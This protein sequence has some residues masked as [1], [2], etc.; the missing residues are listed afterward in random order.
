MAETPSRAEAILGAIEAAVM[1]MRVSLP[2]RIESYDASKQRA[3]I[4]IQLQHMVPDGEG[5]F[6]PTD[7]PILPNVPIMFPQ[8]NGFFV[9]FPLAKGDPV[10][11][12]FCDLPIGTWLQKGSKCEPGTVRFHGLGGAVAYPGL[13][14]S[15]SPL[16]DASG[17]NMVMGKD[18]TSASQIV[19]TGSQVQLGGGA[20]FV[21]LAN[22][23][24]A[25][26]DAFNAAVS[27]WT[28]VPN[29]GGAALKAAL[30]TLYGGT[31]TTDVAATN[32]KAT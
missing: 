2:G 30:T 11:V 17:S 26:F 25:W 7:F 6:V 15:K 16:G 21:A 24:K 27:G 1:D 20:Q 32:V 19:L 28:P 4:Q 29:D 31:P 18:G 14:P 22:K 5:G 3:D 23:V 13:Q 9:S 12:V 10:L 8:G